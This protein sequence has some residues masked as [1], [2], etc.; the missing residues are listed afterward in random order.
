MA[1]LMHAYLKVILSLESTAL[2]GLLERRNQAGKRVTMQ[3]P[4]VNVSEEWKS[5]KET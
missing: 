1:S 2:R 3:M 5:K 4:Y